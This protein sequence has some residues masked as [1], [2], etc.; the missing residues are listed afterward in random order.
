MTVRYEEGSLHGFVELQ[1]LAGKDVAFGEIVQTVAG[2]RVTSRLVLRFLDGALYDDTTVFTQKR[3]FRLVHDHL[4]QRGASF[5][6]QMETTVDA[7]NG[8]ISVR[9]RDKDGRQKDLSQQMAI[10]EDA[11]NGLLF[12]ILKNV[13]PDAPETSVSMVATTPKPRLVQIRIVPGGYENFSIGALRLQAMHYVL[14]IDIGGITGVI[15][16]LIGKQP[17]DMHGWVVETGSPAVIRNEGPLE[18][19]GSIWRLQPAPA[20]SPR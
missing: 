20:P 17:P 15:A 4:I 7:A 18:S 6:Q 12:T 13:R 19:D 9:Y 5:K 16:P 1:T 11:A 8:K 2:G 14:K 10:P 3:V